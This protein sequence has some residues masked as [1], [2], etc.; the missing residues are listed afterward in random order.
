MLTR[1]IKIVSCL[2]FAQLILLCGHEANALNGIQL[3]A[4]TAVSRSVGGAGV[5]RPMDSAAIIINPA[6]MNQVGRYFDL[7]LT[8]GFPDNTMDSSAAPAGNAVSAGAKSQDEGVFLP[9]LGIITTLLDDRLALGIGTYFAGGFGVD[10][11]VSRLTNAVTADAYDR[12]GHYALIKLIPAVSYQLLDNLSVG[13]ALHINYS[14][15]HS[16]SATTA[17]GF[18]ET[19]GA[20]RFDPAL[21][22]GAHVGLIYRPTQWMS[23]GAD[24][25]TRQ[26]FEKFDRYTDLLIDSLDMPMQVTGGVA[27]DPFKNQEFIILGDFRWIN[28][29]GVGTLGNSVTTGGFGWRDQYIFCGGVQYD[30]MQRVKLPLE[31]SL[32]YNYGRSPIPSSSVFT[33]LLIPAISQHNLTGGLGYALSERVKLSGT[34]S[35]L[36]KSTVTD[37][38]SVNPLAAGATMS[39]SA[40]VIALQMGLGL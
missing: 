23:L 29:G 24:Y 12:S 15:L 34:Y 5:A 6:G 21:G 2:V 18:P 25:V 17:A 36:F 13:L 8:I 35:Y 4:N 32:G 40:H 20:S 27:F 7:N 38:G 33:N 26:Y 9:S 19:N 1:L 11:S 28:W 10:Y 14:F 22:V 16:D 30:F 31:A 3:M 37:D 39:S